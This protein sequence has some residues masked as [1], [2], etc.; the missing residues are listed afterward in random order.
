M[1]HRNCVTSEKQPGRNHLNFGLCF[2]G[3]KYPKQAASE[4]DDLEEDTVA[5]IYQ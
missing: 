1:H 4:P 3:Q 2:P 5:G